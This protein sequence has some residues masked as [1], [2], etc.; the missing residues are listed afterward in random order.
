ML[1][2][3]QQQVYAI[4]YQQSGGT[5]ATISNTSG[6]AQTIRTIGVGKVKWGLA[7][8][9]ACRMIFSPVVIQHSACVWTETSSTI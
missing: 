5:I 1:P 3:D 2:S 9:H 7:N 4:E 6:V 8:S